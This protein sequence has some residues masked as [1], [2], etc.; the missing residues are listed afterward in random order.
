MM[1]NLKISSPSLV[2]SSQFKFNVMNRVILRIMVMSASRT[3]LMLR[4]LS[5]K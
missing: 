4:L 1:F 2:R 5:K 3:L